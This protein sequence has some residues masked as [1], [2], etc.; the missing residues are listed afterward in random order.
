[1]FFPSLGLPFMLPEP[2]IFVI[3]SGSI[4]YLKPSPT[5]SPFTLLKHFC[6]HPTSGFTAL[7]HSNTCLLAPSQS[8]ARHSGNTRSA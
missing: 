2:F 6:L 5:F 1:M 8:H 3:T 4:S 7:I